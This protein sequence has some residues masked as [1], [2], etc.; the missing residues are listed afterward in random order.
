MSIDLVHDDVEK[1]LIQVTLKQ[2]REYICVR[3]T[4][5]NIVGAKKYSSFTCTATRKWMLSS[6]VRKG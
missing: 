3:T 2:Q 1:S 4:S 6:R 5:E